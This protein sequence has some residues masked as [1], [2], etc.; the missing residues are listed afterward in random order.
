MRR[1]LAVALLL[2]MSL[3]SGVATAAPD[4]QRRKGGGGGPA[5]LP[6]PRTQLPRDRRA[7][8]A[9]P[10]DPLASIQLAVDLVRAGRPAEAIPYFGFAEGTT[11]FERAL[12]TY[13]DALREVGRGREAAELRRDRG[14]EEPSLKAA[15]AVVAD[16][17]A[18]GDRL[19]ALD[20]VEEAEAAFP[21]AAVVFDYEA[22]VR[23][24]LGEVA[25]AEAA[26]ALAWHRGA[27]TPRRVRVEARLL[28]LAGDQVAA[29]ALME[30]RAHGKTAKEDDVH[31]LGSLLNATGEGQRTLGILDLPRWRASQ[32]PTLQ[33]I[34]VEAL[35][36][37]GRTEEAFALCRTV[38]ATF[39]DHRHAVHAEGMVRAATGRSC[40]DP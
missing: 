32:T 23:L 35:L 40:V 21:G 34:R 29:L 25:E 27:S 37:A 22:D 33:A 6:F 30:P 15:L 28:A 11:A 12:P 26:L 39:G 38:A 9:Q 16:L 19:G 2:C 7:V 17:Q 5:G 3:L 1:K 8:E 10:D 18:A 4:G 31:L 36:A 24:D 20:A 13:A 14:G